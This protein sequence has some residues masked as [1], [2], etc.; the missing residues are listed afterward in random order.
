MGVSRIRPSRVLCTVQPNKLLLPDVANR[1]FTVKIPNVPSR[2]LIRRMTLTFLDNFI[3]TT[4]AG[5]LDGFLVTAIGDD[6]TDSGAGAGVNTITQVI[7]ATA[8]CQGPLDFQAS[9]NA[10]AIC[11]L[12]GGTSLFIDCMNLVPRYVGGQYSNPINQLLTGRTAVTSGSGDSN[13]L[14][15]GIPTAEVVKMAL[16][17]TTEIYYDVSAGVKGPSD[18]S[19]TLYFHFLGTGSDMAAKASLDCRLTFEIEPCF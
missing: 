2:G 9:G 13:T 11:G 4:I 18:N 7:A 19:G 3:T 5:S 1:T 6:T 12:D 14:I 10:G 8:I 16:A 17:P 15:A